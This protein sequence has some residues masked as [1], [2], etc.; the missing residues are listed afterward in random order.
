[1]RFGEFRWDG[2]Y[3][4]FVCSDVWLLRGSGVSCVL[5][6][7]ELLVV[8]ELPCSEQ[9]WCCARVKLSKLQPQDGVALCASGTVSDH[10]GCASA[11]IPT[12]LD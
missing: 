7:V 4:C 9:T 12:V 6:I 2:R 3:L 1:M 10:G 11:S 5:L 8:C